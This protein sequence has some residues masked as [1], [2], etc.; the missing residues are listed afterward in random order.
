M[1]TFE[2]SNLHFI[3]QNYTLWRLNFSTHRHLDTVQKRKCLPSCVRRGSFRKLRGC[4][5]ELIVTFSLYIM[6][7]C[8][9]QVEKHSSDNPT[10][11]GN[12]GSVIL[13]FY[14]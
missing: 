7:D 4:G 10:D 13:D 11:K 5:I 8:S 9:E 2:L 6:G 14:F 1:R 12:K 3:F